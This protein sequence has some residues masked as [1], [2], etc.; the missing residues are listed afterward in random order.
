MNT[1]SEVRSVTLLSFHGK[2]IPCRSL[3]D[4]K[5]RSQALSE[6][7]KM[8][9]V[10]DKAQDVQAVVQLIDQLQKSILIYQVCPQ[11]CQG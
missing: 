7:G 10:L 1:T 3:N 6:K 8:A 4:I 5:K 11:S 2:L 9:R